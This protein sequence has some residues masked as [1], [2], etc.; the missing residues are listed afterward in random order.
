MKRA[1]KEK[2][3]KKWKEGELESAVRFYIASMLY[4]SDYFWNNFT[5]ENLSSELDANPKYLFKSVSAIKK[6]P[7]EGF[8]ISEDNRPPDNTERDKHGYNELNCNDWNA[9]VYY[10]LK[11]K[12]DFFIF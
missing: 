1:K 9:T 11:R 7:P 2:K 5:I 4:K 10:V 6:R 8:F 3:Y 12:A